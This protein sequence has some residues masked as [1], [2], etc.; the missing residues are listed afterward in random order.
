MNEQ[1]GEY[2]TPGGKLVVVDLTIA[3]GRLATAQVSGDFFLYPDETLLSITGALI[4]META[5]ALEEHTVA[6][7]ITAALP[8]DAV[9]LGFTPESVA[10]AVRRALVAEP[11]SEVRK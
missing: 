4:G 5:I 2:K 7:Q 10:R 9:L 3:E 8:P 1:H 11:E 6:S